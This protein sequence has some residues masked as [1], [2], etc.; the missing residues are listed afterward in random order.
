[1]SERRTYERAPGGAEGAGLEGYTVFDE[2]GEAVGRVTSVTDRGGEIEL[3]LAEG[4]APP[5]GGTPAVVSWSAVRNVDH[6]RLA[7]EIAET[8]GADEVR[9]E[10][11]VETDGGERG[12]AQR[13]V[14]VPTGT[15]P[16]V[17]ADE[18]RVRSRLSVAVAWGVLFLSSVLFLPPIAFAFAADSMW[19]L[20]L[21]AVPAA[22]LALGVVLILRTLRSPYAA[23]R[24]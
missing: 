9:D 22:G 17:P 23:P 10:Q 14:D 12:A 15:P 5:F 20:A 21:L 13:V 11:L 18:A 3:V 2:R 16:P 1:V 7:I 24:R 8:T 19:W 6:E 4:G